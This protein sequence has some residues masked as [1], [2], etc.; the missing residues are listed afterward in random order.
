VTV[1]AVYAVKGGVGKTTTT[2]NLAAAL[3]KQGNQKVLIIDTNLQLPNIG[4]HLGVPQVDRGLEE[5]LEGKYRMRDAIYHHA[6]GFDVLLPQRPS[7]LKI[8]RLKEKIAVIKEKYDMILLDTMPARSQT[9]KAVL[10]S[11]DGVLLVTTTDTPTLVLAQTAKTELTSQGY[12]IKGV[13]CNK[14]ALNKEQEEEIQQMLNVPVLAAVPESI[15]IAQSLA[16]VQSLLEE[17]PKTAAARAYVR[18]AQQISEQ[19]YEEESLWQ[20]CSARYKEQWQRYKL[21]Q[22]PQKIE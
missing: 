12:T 1:L 22:R 3:A 9:Q 16:N 18:C 5:V 10:E 6:F 19:S 13:L 20:R 14:A 7:T 4:L 8:N 21:H 15:F 11:A 17:Q 2:I